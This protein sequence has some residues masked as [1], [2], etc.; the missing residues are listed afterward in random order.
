MKVI[1]SSKQ[2]Q[3]I[4]IKHKRQGKTIGFVPTMGALHE[5]HLSLVTAARKKNDIVV[6][7]IFVNPTQFGPK[8]DY[9]RYPRPFEK[10]RNLCRKA[11]VDYIFAPSVEDTY[12]E[13]YQT[14]ITV[15]QLSTLYCGAFRPGHFRG[16]ASV[17][18]K[19][20]N[21][22]QPDRAYFG[23]KDYQQLT[24]IRRMVRDLNI[25]VTIVPCAIIRE[26]SGLALSSRNQYLL[27]EERSFS[28]VLFQSLQQVREMVQCFHIKNSSK[29]IAKLRKNILAIPGVSIDYIAIVDPLTLVPI[30]EIKTSVRILL[31]VW[32]GKTR[33]IDNIEVKCR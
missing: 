16:V 20:F 10:D 18:A 9:L 8:E 6:V 13:G 7:S 24:I 33:L 12:P 27:Q 1:R 17:V 28:L 31:A 21:I 5:G 19:F 23:E 4:C 26:S 29:I 3:A 32:I 2:M 30:K 25:P 14:Y 15:E 11:G 22:T